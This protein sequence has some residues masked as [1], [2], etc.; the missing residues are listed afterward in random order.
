MNPKSILH[1]AVKAH[2]GVLDNPGRKDLIQRSVDNREAMINKN[3]ALATWTPTESTGRSPKDTLIVQHHDTQHTIDWTSPN[4]IPIPEETFDMILQDAIQFMAE[5]KEIY[6]TNRVIGADSAYALPVKTITSHALHALFTDNMF[7]PVMA[8]IQNSCFYE[9][10]FTLLALPYHKL[11]PEKYHGKLRKMPDGSTSNMVVAMDFDRRVGII[12]GSAYM[13]SIKKMLFTVMNYLLLFEDILPL[14]CSANEGKDGKSALLLGLSG[15]GKTT[16][17]ADPERL[18]L[19]DDEHGWGDSGIANFEYGCYAKMIDINPKKEPD[20]YDAVM[21]QDDY[22]NHGAIIENAMIY[23]NGEVDY[24]D[25]RFTQNSRASYPLTMLKT[26]KESSKSVHPSTILFLT[27]DAYGV[28]PPVSKLNPDQAMLWFLMGYT[29][30]LAGTETGIKEPQATFSRFFGAPFMPGLPDIYAR[31]LGEK[32]EKHNTEVYL[33]NTGWTAGP[34]GK[35][36]RID[37]KYTRAMVNAAFSGALSN[38]EY[39]YDK[40]FHLNIPATCPG[41]PQDILFPQ[42]TWKNKEEYLETAQVLAKQFSDAFDKAYGDKNIS[43]KVTSY[44][45]GK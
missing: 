25:D 32:M 41:V 35:G 36:H 16:L 29:S 40:I 17:S 7:R 42:S 18:L 27:A 10:G 12:V 14:H 37:L 8:D 24:Y 2:P 38:S 43:K 39:S 44:C 21:H 1:E 34:Y 4:N 15:T 3:G 30:K 22:L 9:N 20:I 26:I 19:G 23:P 11:D 6:V 5:T 31:M 13:G 33:I 28:L 45:P